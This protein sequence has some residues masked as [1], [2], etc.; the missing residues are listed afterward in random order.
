MDTSEEDLLLPS[1]DAFFDDSTMPIRTRFFL[2]TISVVLILS[3]SAFAQGEYLRPGET[4][5]GGGPLT[6][7]ATNPGATGMNAG[8]SIC[9]SFD[10]AFNYIGNDEDGKE[11]IEYHQRMKGINNI[12]LAAK[13]KEYGNPFKWINGFK[14]F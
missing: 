13:A 2:L 9:G 4:G 8:V 12:A 5:I 3:G 7:F 10:V 6:T 1:N 11:Y 14:I